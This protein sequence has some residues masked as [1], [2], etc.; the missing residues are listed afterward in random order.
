MNTWARR[1]LYSERFPET[2]VTNLLAAF[3][4]VLSSGLGLIIINLFGWTETVNLIFLTSLLFLLTIILNKAGYTNVGRTLFCLVP[5]VMGFIISVVSKIQ[6][7]NQSYIIY[8]DVRYVLLAS[9]ILPAIVYDLAEKKQLFFCMAVSFLL[10]LLFDPIHNALGIGFFQRGFTVQSYYYINYI[11]FISFMAITSGILVLKWRHWNSELST[12][13]ALEENKQI[14]K[15]LAERNESL[16]RV[17]NEVTAQNEEILQQQEEMAMNQEMLERANQV[18]IQQKNKLEEYNEQLQKKVEEKAGDLL[19]TNHELIQSNNELRQFSFSVSH[20]LRGPVARILGL[21]QLF[22]SVSSEEVPTI[23]GHL[24]QSAADL[25]AVLKDLNT[26]IEIRTNLFNIREKIDLA[27]ELE[28]VKRVIGD[29]YFKEIRLE[30]H[31]EVPH[32][33]GIKAMFN[34]ILYNLISNALKYQSAERNLALVIK[35]WQTDEKETLISISDNGL[36]ID[37]VQHR[38]HIF[39]LYKRFHLHIPGKGMGLYLV[40]TQMEMM[41]GR[42]AVESTLNVGSQ[43]VLTFPKA[44]DID[45]QVFFENES[46]QLYY[47]ANINNTV[48]IW[49][50]NVTTEQYRTAFEAVLSTIKKYNTP[51]WIAD[52]RNQGIIASEDQQWF[53]NNVL[54]TASESGLVRIAAIGFHDPIRKDYYNRMIETTKKFGIELRVFT[55]MPDAVNWMG[56]FQ[57]TLPLKEQNA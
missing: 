7:P 52:L 11:T 55:E 49:K 24:Q 5:T 56:T 16:Q 44:K 15:V 45:H 9:S 27:E 39:N 1:I 23:V 4:S 54:R 33:Y 26:V 13:A 48:I 6:V 51:G 30:T 20:N 22:Q 38:N 32:I 14:N 42:V 34:S 47:D 36:G 53:M 19:K 2:Y 17:T 21:T 50:K 31:F 25:D 12:K 18:I 37:L 57:L 35:S 41:G 40:K 29:P 43:F 46:A 3:F 8:F 10:L 28:H